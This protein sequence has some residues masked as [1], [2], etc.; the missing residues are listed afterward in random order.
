VF[1]IRDKALAEVEEYVSL[2]GHAAAEWVAPLT[3]LVD[4]CVTPKDQP[5]PA[6][7]AWCPAKIDT[8]HSHN[9]SLRS[10]HLQ[11]CWG[12]EIGQFAQVGGA[13]VRHA[14]G[15]VAILPLHDASLWIRSNLP[16]Q[17]AIEV[18]LDQGFTYYEAGGPS[19][20]L[21]GSRALQTAGFVLVADYPG[22]K[23]S[24]CRARFGEWLIQGGLIMKAHLV[25]A[26]AAQLAHTDLPADVLDVVRE[27]ALLNRLLQMHC[28]VGA[29]G[30]TVARLAA[31]NGVLSDEHVAAIEG[32][33]AGRTPVGQVLLTSG[34][35]T[36]D[37]LAYALAG[38][39][40]LQ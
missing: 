1:V 14:G 35:I 33:V 40:P 37:L 25:A 29:I 10:G 3:L 5:P 4:V 8:G 20:P 27:A 9:V 34:A 24:L 23:Y 16:G 11:N 22:L 6:G 18:P 17:G 13:S 19:L 15:D 7:H 36:E 32:C 26:L 12:A 31:E 30:K 2:P 21:I 28:D 39:R 38:Y